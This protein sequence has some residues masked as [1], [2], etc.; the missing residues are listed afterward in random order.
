MLSAVSLNGLLM[1]LSF[2]DARLSEPPNIDDIPQ[3]EPTFDPNEEIYQQWLGNNTEQTKYFLK[4]IRRRTSIHN[5]SNIEVHGVFELKCT[6]RYLSKDFFIK[7]H[8]ANG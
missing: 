1:K 7:P 8:L 3:L 6:T 2:T 5:T 4:I